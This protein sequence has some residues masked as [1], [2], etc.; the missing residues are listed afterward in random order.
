MAAARTG[1]ARRLETLLRA[2][3]VADARDA[4]GRT[5]LHI[6]AAG[7]HA[8]AA[9]CLLAY[10][11]SHTVTD[12]AGRTALGPESI[13]VEE[14]HAV[15][16]RFHR[17]RR[18]EP[19]IVATAE[20][21]RWARE[22][23]ERGIV[24]VRGLVGAAALAEMRGAADRFVA[25]IDAKLARGEGSKRDY[26]EEEHW[27]PSDRAY[28]TNN[29]FKHSPDLAHLACRA[30]LID[31]ATLYL[32]QRPYVQR[33]VI[34]RYL[35]AGASNREMFGWHHDLEDRRFKIM[36]LLTD[37]GPG[38]QHM[39]YVLGSHRPYHPFE[40][41]LRN[42]Y[43]L[44]YC[45]RHVAPLEVYDAVGRAGDAFLFDSNGAHRGVRRESGRVRDVALIELT[46]DRSNIWGG[47]VDPRVLDGVTRPGYD[48]FAPFIA[49]AKKWQR[50]R[51][52]APTWVET[53]P[54]VDAWR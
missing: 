8:D 27:W 46:N 11:A 17:F 7:G 12:R 23:D 20:A 40:M 13:A 10:G 29:A 14:L 52:T 41:F 3:A 4:H 1:D 33:G 9:A 31:A 24:E 45:R 30:S 6:A 26:D 38:D 2:G 53:L 32:G 49:A 42:R 22:L 34:M 15:R 47:D 5:A 43:D 37:V 39:S 28:V 48:P 51:R 21:R 54:D 16:Q 36:V 18:A 35:P 44:G 25:A 19:D 50:P